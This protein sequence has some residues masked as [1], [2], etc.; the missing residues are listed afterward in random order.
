MMTELVTEYPKQRWKAY[1]KESNIGTVDAN[2]EF[3]EKLHKVYL[4]ICEK[5]S[6][7]VRITTLI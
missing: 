5:T 2:R 4:R 6:Y 3:A 1:L 7:N